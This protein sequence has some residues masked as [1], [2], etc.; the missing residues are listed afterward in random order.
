M[1]SRRVVN[2]GKTIIINYLVRQTRVSAQE[3]MGKNGLN[4]VLHSVGSERFI[5]MI[6]LGGN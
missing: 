3:V 2:P 5:I 4:A 1:T 6:Q